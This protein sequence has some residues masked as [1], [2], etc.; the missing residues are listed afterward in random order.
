[1]FDVV[2]SQGF[3]PRGAMAGVKTKNK[4]TRISKAVPIPNTPV[5]CPVKKASVSL[6]MGGVM[7]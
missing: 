2:D 5:S 7:N 1:M 4:H 6:D 3:E